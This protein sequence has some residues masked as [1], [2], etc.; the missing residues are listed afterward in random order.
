MNNISLCIGIK[1][2]QLREGLIIVED[3]YKIPSMHDRHR[4]LS[5]KRSQ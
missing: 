5:G 4:R 1:Y 3:S 2:N